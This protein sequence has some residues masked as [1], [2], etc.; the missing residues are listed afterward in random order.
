MHPK[1]YLCSVERSCAW[2][3]LQRTALLS[4]TL[5]TTTLSVLANTT[6][7]VEPEVCSSPSCV[8]AELCILSHQYILVHIR[9]SASLKN[10][11]N[12]MTQCNAHARNSNGTGRDT[13]SGVSSKALEGWAALKEGDF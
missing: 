4:P 1:S 3:A 8:S 13:E 11:L 7:A 5:A 6:V 9:T 12:Y 10:A 2:P